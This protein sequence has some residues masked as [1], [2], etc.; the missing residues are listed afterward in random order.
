MYRTAASGFSAHV[1]KHAEHTGNA[2]RFSGLGGLWDFPA[3]LKSALRAA[4]GLGCS[5]P[6]LTGDLSPDFLELE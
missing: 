6:H 1:H 3:A 2:A 5:Q 4:G